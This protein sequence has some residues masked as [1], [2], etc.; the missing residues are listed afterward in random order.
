MT[1]EEQSSVFTLKKLILKTSQNNALEQVL[2]KCVWVSH[3][4][5]EFPNVTWYIGLELF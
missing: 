4:L 1:F 2:T 3:F 5:P